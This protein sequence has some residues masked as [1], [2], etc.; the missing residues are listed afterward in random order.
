MIKKNNFTCKKLNV[1]NK[2]ISYEIIFLKKLI[3]KIEKMFYLP[4]LLFVTECSLQN[5]QTAQ[6]DLKKSP[7]TLFLLFN[8]MSVLLANCN[9]EKGKVIHRKRS[10]TKVPLS[11]TSFYAFTYRSYLL[12]PCL[13]IGL[14]NMGGC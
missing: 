3:S 12:P 13:T 1:Y 10:L 6:N 14:I 8:V 4:F 2:I 11:F 9:R 5:L 7:F